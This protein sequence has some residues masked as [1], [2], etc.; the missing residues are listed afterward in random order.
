MPLVLEG[1]RRS[2]SIAWSD[3]GD[4]ARELQEG[5]NRPIFSRLLG[6]ETS[7]SIPELDPGLAATR[8]RASPTWAAAPGGP[9]SRLRRA[10]PKMRV[11]GVDFDPVASQPLPE[12]RPRPVCPAPALRRHRRDDAARDAAPVR[13]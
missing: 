7:P 4:E 10:Y 5:F 1:H 11:D 2:G 6:T 13:Q 9:A 12:M 3:I 8:R